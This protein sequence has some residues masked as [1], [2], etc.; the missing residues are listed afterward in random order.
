MAMTAAEKKSLI[1]CIKVG[2]EESARAE[3]PE[4]VGSDDEGVIVH[5]HHPHPER[6]ET[7]LIRVKLV[8]VTLDD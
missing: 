1:A 5:Y 3:A 2:L 6:D 7:K 8:P 4:P